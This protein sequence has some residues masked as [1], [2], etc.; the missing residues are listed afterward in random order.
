M[1]DTLM[2]VLWGLFGVA[3]LVGIVLLA[4]RNRARRELRETIQLVQAVLAERAHP[5]DD[6]MDIADAAGVTEPEERRRG[7]L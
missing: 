2:V 7:H 1:S 5:G 3:L 4:R 6:L